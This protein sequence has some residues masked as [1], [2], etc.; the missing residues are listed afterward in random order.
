MKARWAVVA[1]FAAVALSVVVWAV[2]TNHRGPDQGVAAC[3][4]MAPM[5]YSNSW[6]P[7]KGELATMFAASRYADLRAL[8]PWV[9]P[10]PLV[11]S[12]AD[13]DWDVLGRALT[14]AVSAY[15]A[16]AK[17]CAAHGAPFPDITPH[18]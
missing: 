15:L 11:T 18:P 17:A 5:M 3:Q 12:P 7:I 8:V 13:I 9:D 16:M 4:R 1:A 6:T 2:L 10:T 14:F